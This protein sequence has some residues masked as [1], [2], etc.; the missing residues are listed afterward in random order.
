MVSWYVDEGLQQLDREW[1]KVHPDAVVYHIGDLNH[2]VNPDVSQH[3]PDRGG[4]L[5]GDDKGEVDASDFMP[6]NGVTEDDLDDLAEQLRLSKDKRIL[7][8]IRRQRIFSSVVQP[9]MWRPYG[10]A[11]HGHCHVSVNDLFD[12][13]QS[14]WNWEKL[15]ARGEIPTVVVDGLRVPQLQFGDD[16]AADEGYNPVIRVQ[17]LANLLDSKAEDIQVDGVYGAKTAAKFKAMFG[18][19]GKKLTTAQWRQLVGA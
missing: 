1:K 16:D 4:S 19:D 13:N 3:A 2:S 5:P 11:Y 18:G 9:W 10:G 17:A 12:N 8:V 14:D 15:V 7:Y 6:G